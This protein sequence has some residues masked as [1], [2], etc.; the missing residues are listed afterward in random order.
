MTRITR[1]SF[2]AGAA[3]AA[4]FTIIK[5]DQVRGTSANARIRIGAVG[6]GGRGAWISD[7]FA[8]H[9]GYQI[10]AVA[11]YF[12]E[13]ATA[14]GKALGVAP[15]R[16][17]SGLSGYIR[18]IDSGVDAVLLE[19]PPYFFPEQAAV[20]VDAGKHVYMA[21]PVASDVPGAL[22]I[23]AAA[24]R[25]ARN[26]QVFLVDYQIPT[27]PINRE[28]AKRVREGGLG[29]IAYLQ[30]I[31]ISGVFP[32]PPL[33]ATIESRLRKLIWVN[34][35]ALGC[36]YIG[37]F[38]IHAIDAAVWLLGRRPV[39]AAGHSR[40]C[41]PNPHG[42]SR[43]VIGVVYEFEDK[44]ILN[45]RGQSLKN[46]ADDDG[47]VC[48]VYGSAAMA[49]INY[50]GKAFVRGGTKHY[51]GGQVTDLYLAGAQR[52][53]AA[54]HEK[55]TKG[56]FNND[57]TVKHAIDSVLT[58]ILGREAAARGHMMTMAQLID[59]NKRLEVNLEGLKD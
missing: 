25:A 24:R 13:V 29:R 52:N 31:G 18:L 8:K 27:D 7:L 32:D 45:H 23:E 4:A 1:R 44:T 21:K 36:D 22:R 48:K 49:Q 16:C 39:S 17:F 37:N 38:D 9:G 26:K 30:T 28:V 15:E 55:I 54:F 42:D 58:C 59:E 12:P 33:T 19:V 34:D 5:P 50:W 40:I 6:Q 53:I 10:T 41:R 35:I 14:K 43:D 56:D 2:L 51:G 47:L 46:N 3:T 20:A 57:D 11:D